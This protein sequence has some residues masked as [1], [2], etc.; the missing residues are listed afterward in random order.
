VWQGPKL[1]VLFRNNPKLLDEVERYLNVK[2]EVGSSIPGCE[3]S[4]L[5]DRITCQVV[6]NY[7]LCFGVDM[8]A[9]CL[10]KEKEKVRG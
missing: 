7:L 3:I 1:E 2:E 5:L 6:V 4:S 8:S 9:L 10:K